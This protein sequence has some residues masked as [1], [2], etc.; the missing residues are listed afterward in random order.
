[1]LSMTE[2]DCESNKLREPSEPQNTD[3]SHEE[4]S[5]T[6]SGQTIGLEPGENF[7]APTMALDS[8][9]DSHQSETDD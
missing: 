4:K 7:I 9:Q 2:Q 5:I 3:L 8:L 6:G 1:M